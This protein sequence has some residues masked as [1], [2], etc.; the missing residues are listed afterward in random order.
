[1]PGRLP[2]DDAA[3]A[4]ARQHIRLR[5]SPALPLRCLESLPRRSRLLHGVPAHVVGRAE[6][7]TAAGRVEVKDRL[8]P[9]EPARATPARRQRHFLHATLPPQTIEQR[10]RLSR[11]DGLGDALR[12]GGISGGMLGGDH[13][14]D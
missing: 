13:C 3:A 14:R 12:L 7:R 2:R 6:R 8:A 11:L 5:A 4:A 9:A 1:M 10:E